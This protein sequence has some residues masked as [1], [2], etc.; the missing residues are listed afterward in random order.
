MSWEV[1]PA[2]R[3]SSFLTPP[4]HPLAPGKNGGLGP[5]GQMELVEDVADMAFNGF[6]ADDQPLGNIG[7][8]QPIG[9]E[10]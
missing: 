9:D 7:V 4:H 1:M 6:I 3:L 2:S 8:A 10:T 5:V